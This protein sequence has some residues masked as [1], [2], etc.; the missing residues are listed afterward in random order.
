M[1]ICTFCHPV[2]WGIIWLFSIGRPISLISQVR[3]QVSTEWLWSQSLL[4][5]RH[6]R[7][8]DAWIHCNCSITIMHHSLWLHVKVH[9]FET[10]FY[11]P[12]LSACHISD[13]QGT[14]LYVG[15]QI[16]A[17]HYPTASASFPVDILGPSTLGQVM[18]NTVVVRF[19]LL[20][21]FMHSRHCCRQEF[22]PHSRCFFALLASSHLFCLLYFQC[23]CDLPA[24]QFEF[25]SLPICAQVHLIFQLFLLHMAPIDIVYWSSNI[26]LIVP[27]QCGDILPNHRLLLEL[28]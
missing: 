6:R 12:G 2:A 18:T 27:P 15:H 20:T 10:Y 1:S 28:L 17:L 8:I 13:S 7:H 9:A 11:I 24:A 26:C 3:I 25:F 22:A 21:S 14:A 4:M 19:Q 23:S 16:L 5:D